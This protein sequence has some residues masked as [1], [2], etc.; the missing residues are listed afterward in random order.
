M[1]GVFAFMLFLFSVPLLGQNDSIPDIND[2]QELE[3]ATIEYKIA[4]ADSGCPVKVYS[5]S[6]KNL[7]RS[8]SSSRILAIGGV[9]G[10]NLITA[11]GGTVR[12]AIR[13]LSGQRVAT[14]YR[15]ARIESQAWGE[16][17]GIYL[18]E[19]GVSRVEVI[20]GP[21]ALAYG[22][23]CIGGVVNFAQETPLQEIGSESNFSLRTFSATEGYKA[24]IITRRRS[25]NAHHSFCGGYNS[26]G[27]Y[28]TPT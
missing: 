10:V 4:G 27:D 8:A 3:G 15:G 22:A 16:D 9:P 7:D 21:S 26:H 25:A 2:L 23:D 13:G 24:S 12:P 19:Q 1:R 6:V 28:V 20:K 5:M 14:L 18:P 17:H 11:G